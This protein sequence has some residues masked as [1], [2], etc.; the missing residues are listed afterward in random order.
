MLD[1]CLFKRTGQYSRSLKL[2]PDLLPY[3]SEGI[4]SHPVQYS[5]MDIQCPDASMRAPVES[6]RQVC[7]VINS[8][9]CGLFQ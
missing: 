6:T 2:F 7:Q 3:I 8:A 4:R 5:T 1:M 9:V